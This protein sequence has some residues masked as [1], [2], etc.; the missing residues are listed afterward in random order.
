MIAQLLRRLPRLRFAQPA[1]WDGALTID[2][3]TYRVDEPFA[4]YVAQQPPRLVS[5]VYVGDYCEPQDAI[6]S[7]WR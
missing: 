3:T 7:V 1:K 6:M 2:G 5:R 4:A